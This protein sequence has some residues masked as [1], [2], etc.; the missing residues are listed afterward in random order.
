MTSTSSAT[1]DPSD[2]G[3]WKDIRA[4]YAVSDDFINLENGFFSVQS[5]PVFEAFQAYNALVNREGAYFMRVKYQARLASVMQALSALTGAAPEELVLT[6]N[7]TEAMNILI[8]DY[9][10]QAGDEV[11]VATDDY[12]SVVETFE[13]MQK[14]HAIRLVRI[15]LPLDPVEDEQIVA[16]YERAITARTRVLLLTHLLHTTGQ[17]LPVAKIAEMARGRGVDLLVDA[18]HSFAHIDYRFAD[19]NTDFIAVNL[20]KWLGAPLG[21][22]LL[23]I[24]SERITDIAPLFSDTHYPATDIR[25]L[26][27]FGTTPPA[28]VLAIEDAIAFHHRIG[29]RNKE[30]RLRFL[31][32]YWVDRVRDFPRIEL[33]TPKTSQR[34]C[35]IAA[36]R[37]AG[38]AAQEVA[39]TLFER[40][41][42][43]TVARKVDG[44]WGVRV[45]PHLYNTTGDLDC[46]VE[47]LRRLACT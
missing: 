34:A 5:T 20:H 27:H 47:A 41:R 2:E 37:I 26:A 23:Y 46:L 30:A 21:V 38:M 17:I 28:P 40:D 16:L 1:I 10:F 19:L 6:R 7:T 43:F 45:T 42:I 24:R 15:R 4:Q 33:L 32:D 31:K 9:P 13:M 35:A 29:G 44:E 3:F 12:P 11:V 18:A 36:F 8:Q 25:K 14:R 39:E 22:G